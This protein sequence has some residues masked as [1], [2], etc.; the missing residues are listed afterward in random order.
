[1][2]SLFTIALL[3][4]IT[5]SFAQTQSRKVEIF[6]KYENG[7]LVES[8]SV[9]T[10]GEDNTPEFNQKFDKKFKDGFGDSFDFPDMGDF[11][12]GDMDSKMGG[13]DGMD[14][15]SKMAEMQARMKDKQAEMELKMEEMM[16]KLEVKITEM[17]GHADKM[18]KDAEKRMESSGKKSKPST[19]EKT[20]PSVQPKSNKP[21]VKPGKEFY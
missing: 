21:A 18:Q 19:P 15:S 11:S 17:K 6:K 12:F 4:I 3:A 16:K 20:K 14:M 8:D 5:G 7:V 1:M 13:K 9:V 2:K 10:E